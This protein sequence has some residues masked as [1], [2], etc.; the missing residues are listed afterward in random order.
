MFIQQD[1]VEAKYGLILYQGG[2]GDPA[3]FTESIEAMLSL[4]KNQL[5]RFLFIS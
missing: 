3:K 4:V 2:G 5:S 1:K